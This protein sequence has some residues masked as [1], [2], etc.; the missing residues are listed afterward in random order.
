MIKQQALQIDKIKPGRYIV[1]VSGGVDSMALLD[2]LLK[3]PQIELIV[4]HFD[5]GIRAESQQD[6]TFVQNY[7]MSHNLKFEFKRA[8]LGVNASEEQARNARYNFLRQTCKNHNADSIVMAHHQDDL[9]ETAI[10]NLLRGTGRHGLTSLNS[11]DQLLRPMLKLTKDQIIRYAKEQNLVWVEDCTN[12]DNKYLRNHIRHNIVEKIDKPTRKK[13]LS[14]IVRHYNI[15]Q[16]IDI[17]LNYLLKRYCTPG[18]TK[19]STLL[20][21]HLL[22]MLPHNVA[23]ELLQMWLKSATGSGVVKIVANHALLFAKTA[24]PH[25]K[26]ELN[27]KY[28]LRILSDQVIVEPKVNMLS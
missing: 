6:R 11:H 12:Q 4:A 3:Q 14:I 2:I 21:R 24:K 10:I 7:S 16:Q 15:N 13:L 17:Q 22:I 20:P 1:A 19:N 18:P 26:F 25:K 5:H 27:K 28:Q 23:Y 8:E 9:L